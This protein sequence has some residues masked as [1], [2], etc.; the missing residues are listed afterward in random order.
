MAECTCCQGLSGFGPCLLWNS[1]ATVFVCCRRIQKCAQRKEMVSK[2]KH[3]TSS[4]RASNNL[5]PYQ[6]SAPH[7]F[8]ARHQTPYSN[9]TT[10][11]AALK[12]DTSSWSTNLLFFEFWHPWIYS[13]LFPLMRCQWMHFQIWGCPQRSDLRD[14]HHTFSF[15]SGGSECFSGSLGRKQTGLESKSRERFGPSLSF[16]KLWI[17]V[18]GL[19]FRSCLWI[20]SAL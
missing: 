12:P 5:T 13:C 15:A 10:I 11:W 14:G 8:S 20:L 2:L 1:C 9:E 3:W 16:V 7:V 4:D 17:A 6:T 18:S 19:F